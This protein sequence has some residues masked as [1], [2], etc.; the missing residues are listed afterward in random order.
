MGLIGSSNVV[1]DAPGVKGRTKGNADAN[2]M[3]HSLLK[4]NIMTAAIRGI[5]SHVR[6]QRAGICALN[7]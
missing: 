2:D 7:L 1:P 6:L 5:G 4:R 3:P